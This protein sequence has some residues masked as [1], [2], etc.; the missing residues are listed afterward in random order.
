MANQNDVDLT[1]ILKTISVSRLMYTMTISTSI[2]F[3][4]S[5]ESQARVKYSTEKDGS[6]EIM[7]KIDVVIAFI[8]NDVIIA[9]AT[10]YRFDVISV[11]YGILPYCKFS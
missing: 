4:I 11:Q 9:M 2:F 5:R 1:L 6:R 8:A 7:K 3:S 10:S